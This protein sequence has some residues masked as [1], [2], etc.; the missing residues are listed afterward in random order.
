MFVMTPE[1]SDF[2]VLCIID[3]QLIG[4]R[5]SLGYWAI[6]YFFCNYEEEYSEFC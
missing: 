1:G 6:V 2:G 5:V 3:S 4:Q